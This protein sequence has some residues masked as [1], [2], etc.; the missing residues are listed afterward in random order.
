[1]LAFQSKK[2]GVA[3]LAFLAIIALVLTLTGCPNINNPSTPTALDLSGTVSTLAGADRLTGLVN[4]SGTSAR[5]YHPTG[6]CLNGG[7]LYVTD[8]DNYVIRRVDLSDNSVT[9]FAGTGGTYGNTNG[10]GTS[11]SFGWLQ[12]IC[13]DGTFLYVIDTLYDNIRKIEISN[14]AVT[15]LST[16]TSIFGWGIAYTGGNLYV[17]DASNHQIKKV[18][19]SGGSFSVVA[20]SGSPGR[21][22]GSGSSASFNWPLAIT[23]DG[24]NLFVSEYNNY[25]IRQIVISSGAVSTLAGTGTYGHSNGNGTAASFNT[26][27]GLATDGTNLY[28]SDQGNYLFRKLVISSREVTTLAGTL[29]GSFANGTGTSA[30][31]DMPRGVCVGTDCL[32]VVEYGDTVRKIE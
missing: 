20:G 1:M 16:S 4:A 19:T 24:T 13:T 5:F 14:R 11:A 21:G 28:I 18:S 7:Y 8:T 30:G 31:M 23:T 15:T 29:Y 22:D 25:N 3:T 32:Y 12:G 26:I 6:I 10:T 9:T 17:T 2:T 27:Y